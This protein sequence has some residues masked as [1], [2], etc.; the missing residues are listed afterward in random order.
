[1]KSTARWSVV[2]TT[3]AL[4]LATGY[5]VACGG[6][7][8]GGGGGTRFNG[9]VSGTQAF[10]SPAPAPAPRFAWASLSLIGTAY[11]QV[12][13][14]QV[15]LTGSTIC[16]TTDENGAFSLPVDG[17]LLNPVC[18]TLSGSNFSANL[19]LPFD[20]P[21][22]SI[23]TLSE[24]TCDLSSGSCSAEDV[25]IDEPEEEPSQEV[26]DED[27]PSDPSGVSEPSSP[28]DDISGPDD[29]DDGDDDDVDDDVSEPDDDVSE[30]D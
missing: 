24:I 14:V 12:T 3:M 18:L 21:N 28:D 5:F 6:G 25:D 9:N 15:C 20:V 17:D 8:G 26:S 13:G 30:D 22:G 11:A 1:M 23:V 10:L 27:Q 16:T 2:S 7:G 19:C 29:G 4:L